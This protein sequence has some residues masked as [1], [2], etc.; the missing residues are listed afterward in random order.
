MEVRITYCDTPYI[1]RLLEH[2]L[3]AGVIEKKWIPQIK[4]KVALEG[5]AFIPWREGVNFDG[6]EF[7][8]QFVKDDGTKVKVFPVSLTPWARWIKVGATTDGPLKGLV[9]FMP[10]AFF[11]THGEDGLPLPLAH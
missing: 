8:L 4:A 9:M 3:Q 6:P 10:E 5:K 1:D 11:E 7:S 2:Y